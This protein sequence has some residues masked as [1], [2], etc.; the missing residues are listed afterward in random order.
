MKLKVHLMFAGCCEE[1]LNFYKDALGG[2]IAF[3]FRKKE[4]KTLTI[5]PNEEDK[6][7]HMVMQT[8]H[9]ELSAEDVS[10]QDL[11]VGNNTKLVVLFEDLQY[12]KKLFDTFAVGGKITMPLQKTFYSEAIGELTDRYG[13]SWI[14]EMSGE[15]HM[16]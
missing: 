9:F 8:P 7:L 12:C 5:L 1:A 4:D 10:S 2:D 15:E 13:I 11:V 14:I 6:I 16:A 3:V